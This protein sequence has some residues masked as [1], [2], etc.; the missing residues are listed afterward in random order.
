MKITR[1]ILVFALMCISICLFSSCASI[2]S[3]TKQTV[4]VNTQP[5]GARVFVNGEDQ[6]VVTPATINVPRKKA[7]TYSFQKQGYESGTVTEYGSFNPV[8][9]G[10]IILGGIPGFLVD[11][12]TGAWYKYD[13]TNVFYEFK[14]GFS[15]TMTQHI[16]IEHPTIRTEE[17]TNMV[18]RNNPGDT[19]AYSQDC[20]S[21][22]QRAAEMVS[23]KNYCDAK[24]YYQEYSNCNTEAD[25]STEI[26]MCERL[27]KINVMESVEV[28]NVGTTELDNPASKKVSSAW[29]IITLK[30]GEDIQAIV[31]EIDDIYVKYKKFDNPNG[32]N[33]TL[34]K[35]EIFMILYANGSKDV[36]SDDTKK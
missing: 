20:N 29:D 21:Y 19:E 35:S 26:A 3:G 6:H 2:L 31:Q 30:N 11:L 1:K 15:G 16:P 18:T 12:G 25:V 28:E 10:N 34:K 7:I 5:T 14:S 27:C 13:N 36:F 17:T 33:H 22:L 8:V 23:Q 32:P 4:D 9:V 24:R